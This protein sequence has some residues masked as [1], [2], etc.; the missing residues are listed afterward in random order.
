MIINFQTFAYTLIILLLPAF[1]SYNIRNIV[2]SFGIGIINYWLLVML[3]IFLSNIFNIQHFTRALLIAFNSIVFIT[4]IINFFQKKIIQIDKSFYYYFLFL[5]ILSLFLSLFL[6]KYLIAGWDEYAKILLWTKTIFLTNNIYDPSL[7]NFILGDNP[8]LPILLASPTILFNYYQEYFMVIVY[9]SFHL[10]LLFLIYELLNKIFKNNIFFNITILLLY[11]IAELS[12]KLLPENMQYENLQIYLFSSIFIIF[13]LY[14]KKFLDENSSLISLLSI[15]MLLIFLKS[16]Y[17]TILPITFLFLIIQRLNFKKLLIFTIPILLLLILIKIQI[18]DTSR[19]HVNPFSSDSF[20]FDE[21]IY[22]VF[23]IFNKM[24]YWLLNWKLIITLFSIIF[25]INSFKDKEL[26]STS[27]LFCMW[28]LIYL[29]AVSLVINNCFT[30]TEK[31]YLFAVERYLSIPFRTLHILGFIYFIHFFSNFNKFILKI[32]NIIK[33][34]IPIFL[35]LLINQIFKST[36][37][38]T[39][40][41][42]ALK[43]DSSY[44]K[45]KYYND[46]LNGNDEFLPNYFIDDSDL[47]IYELVRKYNQLELLI[48]KP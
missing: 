2:K 18:P 27:L 29:I 3:I 7:S 16:N 4:F 36:I 37:E 44:S 10:S 17:I 31:K 26:I 5:I 34:L 1:Y 30:D 9:L 22:I 19:C 39:T 20:V 46:Y 42:G 21:Y 35:V 48:K 41:V 12:W 8:G 43:F 23:G 32:K 24:I 38:I 45:I 13:I 11:L 6:N 40:R 28:L 25:L 15:L 47:R 33:I 14:K